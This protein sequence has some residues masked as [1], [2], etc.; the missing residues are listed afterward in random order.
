VR[1]ENKLRNPL[2][3]QR[4]VPHKIKLK[5]HRGTWRPPCWGEITPTFPLVQTTVA[6]PL[7]IGT[8]TS[9]NTAGELSP[10][11]TTGKENA[12][13]LDF[14]SRT[15]HTETSLSSLGGVAGRRVIEV[16]YKCTPPHPLT[17]ARKSHN[18][19]LKFGRMTSHEVWNALTMFRLCSRHCQQRVLMPLPLREPTIW[20]CD[21]LPALTALLQTPPCSRS[22]CNS[23]S[24]VGGVLVGR[25]GY[26]FLLQPF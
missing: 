2:S 23:Y 20:G 5:C 22:I 17:A 10:A 9:R 8:L 19:V 16:Q 1:K 11:T 26:P 7:H 25:R 12:F 18:T 21:Q 4:D 6:V 13:S 3:E 14:S 24:P 15:A